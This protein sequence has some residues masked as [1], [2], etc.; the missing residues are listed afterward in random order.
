MPRPHVPEWAAPGLLSGRWLVVG[1][2]LATV[3]LFRARPRRWA[4]L[5][6]VA[7]TV[8]AAL[9]YQRHIPFLAIA[10]L[11]FAAPAALRSWSSWQRQHGP[12]FRRATAPGKPVPSRAATVLAS[13]LAAVLIA[14]LG[15]TKFALVRRH[16]PSLTSRPARSMS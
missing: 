14:V 16:R 9:R 15:A 3:A 12:S 2:A 4:E 10:V 11:V 5:A 6:A 13:V 1:L 7:V 8:L